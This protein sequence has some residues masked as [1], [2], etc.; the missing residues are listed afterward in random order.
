MRAAGVSASAR[1]G[2]TRAASQRSYESQKAVHE[3]P[4]RLVSA[5]PPA[6]PVERARLDPNWRVAA[7][8][9][10]D[11][12]CGCPVACRGG[13]SRARTPAPARRKDPLEAAGG[14]RAK[15][16]PVTFHDVVQCVPRRSGG[17]PL[18]LRCAG[19]DLMPRPCRS[20]L[21]TT[22]EE[23]Y[24]SPPEKPMVRAARR[25]SCRLASD[26]CLCAVQHRQLVMDL[27]ACPWV[28]PFYSRVL[29]N[30]PSARKARR[31]R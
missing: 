3:L 8:D 13:A 23:T 20:L 16:R 4:Y 19:A 5:L 27:L 7:A 24:G 22:D 15:M 11:S 17:S 12:D 25:S 31:L 2:L 9:A 6:P 1:R 21:R 26:A 18:Q 14:D 29:A 28:F 30:C 10:A